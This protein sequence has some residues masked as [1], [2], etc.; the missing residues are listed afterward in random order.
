MRVCIAGASL[1]RLASLGAVV[2]D[3][4]TGSK[5]ATLSVAGGLLLGGAVGAVLLRTAAAII[6]PLAF[7]GADARLSVF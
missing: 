5:A 3:D 4:E 2:W 6:V 7:C 1:F